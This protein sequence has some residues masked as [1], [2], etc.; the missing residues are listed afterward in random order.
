VLQNHINEAAFNASNPSKGF[1]VLHKQE[2]QQFNLHPV[3]E[4][5]TSAGKIS[6]HLDVSL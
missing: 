2:F 6:L 1:P 3:I 5:D 4:A